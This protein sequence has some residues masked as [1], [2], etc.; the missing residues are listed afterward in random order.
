LSGISGGERDLRRE[1]GNYVVPG[2]V[3]KGGEGGTERLNYEEVRE[4]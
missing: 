3:S 1:K 4:S 2:Q